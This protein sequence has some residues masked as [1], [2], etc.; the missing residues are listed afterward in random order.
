MI[1]K[2]ILLL[3]DFNVGK[4][5]L[6]RRYVD[7]SFNDKY[8]TTI[9]VKISKKQLEIEGLTCELLIWDIEGKTA[10]KHIPHSYYKGASGAIFVCDVNRTETIHGLENHIRTYMMLNPNGKYVVAYNKTDLLTTAQKEALRIGLS[11]ETFMT[12]AKENKN[13]EL[14]FTT[15]AKEIL[16]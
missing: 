8:H 1:R 13:V 2:K 12:S 7:N 15:L 9:G 16:L 4:T 6:I 14:L 10:A 3:G 5:S 11:G